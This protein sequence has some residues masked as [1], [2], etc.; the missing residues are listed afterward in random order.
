MGQLQLPS[1]EQIEAEV[2][3]LSAISHPNIVPLL[4]SSM[5]GPAPCLVYALMEGGSLE[6]RL[7]WPHGGRRP[8]S[9]PDRLIIISDVARGL[10]HLHAT[11]QPHVVHRDVK[12]ANVLLGRGLVGCIG[13]FGIAREVNQSGGMTMTHIQTERVVG[14]L[15]YMAPEYKNGELSTKVDSFAFGLVLLEALTGLPVSNPTAEFRSL[16]SLYEDRFE[17][18]EDLI[19]LLDARA[20][21]WETVMVHIP[22]MFDILSRCLELRRRRR[23]EVIDL[24]EDLERVR[25]AA[26]E[27]KAVREWPAQFMCPITFE[28]MV[29]PVVAQDG[30]TYERVAVEEWLTTNDTSP[31]TGAV[32][33]HRELTPNVALHQLIDQ[34]HADAGPMAGPGQQPPPPPPPTGL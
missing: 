24:I 23:P 30:Q 18:V 2:R 29:D 32:L 12:S 13:D 9:A 21:S 7:A 31:L 26:E 25:S 33:E 16:L 22:T 28:P 14:T 11:V 34:F 3:T 8:L 19:P 1:A 4:G 17:A 20:G 6:D 15:V 5:D 10:A 27:A